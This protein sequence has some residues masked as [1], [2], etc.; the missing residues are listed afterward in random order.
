MPVLWDRKR[1]T[2]VNNESAEIVRM[3]NS[4]FG[5]LADTTV[6]L[7]PGELRDE[8]EALNARIYPSLNNGAY[9]ASVLC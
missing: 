9:P 2:I 6:D 8:I 4:G 1:R 5:D 3:F 7:Y